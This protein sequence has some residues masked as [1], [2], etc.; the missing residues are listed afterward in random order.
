MLADLFH[1]E[2]LSSQL[3]TLEKKK[4]DIQNQ[5]KE[6][7]QKLMTTEKL[8]RKNQDQLD[9]SVGHQRSTVDDESE[10]RVKDE[11]GINR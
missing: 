9:T 5:L 7:D 1:L 10:K 6:A 2:L 8:L 3:N 11:V 4:H